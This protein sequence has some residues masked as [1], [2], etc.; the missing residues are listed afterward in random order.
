ML[1]FE[2]L[3][4]GKPVPTVDAGDMKRVWELTSEV[5]RSH[6]ATPGS[7]GLDVRLIA[8]QCSEGADALAVFFR[9]ALVRPLLDSGLLDNWRD[10]D[11]PYDVV[12][13][14][15]ATFP[16]PEGI[17]NFRPDEFADALSKAL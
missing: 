2:S 8:S 11:R 14:A 7:V 13:Q 17:Q 4:S 6:S 1:D 5:A 12:F 16:L 9:V 10:G 3:S 15:L